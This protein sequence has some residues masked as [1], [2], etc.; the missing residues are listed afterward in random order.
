MCTTAPCW[1]RWHGSSR[2][3]AREC[4]IAGTSHSLC[5]HTHG[6]SNAQAKAHRVAILRKR[7]V[8]PQRWSRGQVRVIPC[9][10]TGTSHETTTNYTSVR[11]HCIEFEQVTFLSGFSAELKYGS[12][13]TSSRPGEKADYA[14]K[15][16]LLQYVVTVHCRD[17]LPQANHLMRRR[18]STF[19]K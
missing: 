14:W 7:P 1:R 5:I 9:A 8:S 2:E 4:Q 6:Y 15:L 13:R 19:S 17:H 16:C 18:N 11:T 12:Q 10:V 3:S